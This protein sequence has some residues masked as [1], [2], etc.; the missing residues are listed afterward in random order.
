M[1]FSKIRTVGTISIIIL[2]IGILIQVLYDPVSSVRHSLL[3]SNVRTELP[4]TRAKWDSLR[5]TD[6]TF[7]IQGDARSICQPSAIIEVRNDEVVKVET[8]DF[9]AADVPVQLLPTDRWAD[10]DWGEEVFLC[11]YFHFTMPQIFTLVEVTL[12]NYPSSIVQVGFDPEYGYVTEFSY[13]IY[14]ASGA[15]SLRID[16]CCNKFIIRNFQPVYVQDDQ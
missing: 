8:K 2:F 9:A 14:A 4:A 15:L 12:R 3:I 10:P 13:G 7:E 1:K 5:I 16:D 11:S 6:Y